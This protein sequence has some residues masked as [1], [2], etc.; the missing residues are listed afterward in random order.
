MGINWR[1]AKNFLWLDAFNLVYP[2]GRHFVLH[3]VLARKQRFLTCDSHSSTDASRS[4][5]AVH[6]HRKLLAICGAVRSATS[7]DVVIVDLNEF[8]LKCPVDTTRSSKTDESNGE[9]SLNLASI[10]TGIHSL[11]QLKTHAPVSACTK[12]VLDLHSLGQQLGRVNPVV[13]LDFASDGRSILIQLGE[14]TWQAVRWEFAGA[15]GILSP[16]LPPSPSAVHW[17]VHN[18]FDRQLLAFLSSDSLRMADVSGVAVHSSY[19]LSRIADDFSCL[20]FVRTD[21]LVVGAVSGCVYLIFR[22]LLA[23]TLKL[24]AAVRSMVVR[25]NV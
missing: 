7:V 25:R 13:S 15:G 20:A 1:P 8:H 19:P 21:V 9:E 16:A 12:H 18:P 14:P 23:Q 22:G 11:H 24:D 4:P 10:M 2:C 3:D 17:A 5:F 6:L